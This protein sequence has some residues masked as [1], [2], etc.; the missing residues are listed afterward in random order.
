LKH[1]TLR[2]EL[3]FTNYSKLRSASQLEKMFLTEAN[4]DL[5]Y[6]HF[7]SMEVKYDV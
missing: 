5:V 4:N 2:D 3:S 6:R 1:Y 7:E